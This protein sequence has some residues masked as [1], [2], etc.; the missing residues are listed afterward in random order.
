MN[1]VIAADK[2][3]SFAMNNYGV[4][5]ERGKGVNKKL[6]EACHIMKWQ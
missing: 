1:V 2:W 3:Y 6:K 5:L 4:M